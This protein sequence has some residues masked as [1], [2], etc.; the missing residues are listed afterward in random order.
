MQTTT[1]GSQP[2]EEYLLIIGTELEQSRRSL[3]E[4]TLMIEQSHAELTKLTQRNA[5]VTSHIQ[6]MQSEIEAVSHTALRDAY[7]SALEVQ[8]RLMVM[9][10]Q[11][12]KLQSEQTSLQRHIKMLDEVQ[13]YLSEKTFY[14]IGF[15][16]DRDS[17]A[18]LEM[19]INDQETVRKRV[20]QQ[21][22]DGPAQALSNFILQA[23]IVSKLFEIDQ[24]KAKD[25]LQN[26]KYSAKSSFQMIRH[27]ISELRPMMLD[28]LGLFPTLRKYL[29]EIKAQTGLEVNISIKGQECRLAPF[30]E[31]M[32]F[33]A[34]Q[35]LVGNAIRYNQDQ[36]LRL[37]INVQ[38][39]IEESFVKVTVSDNGKGFNLESTIDKTT[40]IGI[41]LL[42]ERIEMSGGLIEI[43]TG[44]GKGTRVSFQV[45]FH[46][47]KSEAK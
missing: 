41:K 1:T 23:D 36:S 27:F 5:A 25:E 24:A 34:V 26:L 7:T 4:V 33:R 2:I 43:D 22:H 42:K 10:G 16:A 44:I 31:V 11:L 32:I 19:T 14:P 18:M 13:A 30:I 39:L 38:V 35:E 47:T 6:Q 3:N 46:E 15:K 37:Q 21:L 17:R 8:Q 45:P 9:R 40:G 28:D 20:S 12:E 29:D